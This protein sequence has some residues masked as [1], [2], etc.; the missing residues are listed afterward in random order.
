MLNAQRS[1]GS[2]TSLAHASEA[3]RQRGD[4]VEGARLAR[5]AIALAHSLAQVSEQANMLRLLANQLLRTGDMEDAARAAGEAAALEAKLDNPAG[6]ARALTLQSMAYLELGL[7]EEA[8]ETL[9]VSLEIA[10]RLRDPELLF[11]A[12][13]RVGNA[14]SNLGKHTEARNFLRLALPFST[15]LGAES[16]FCILNNLASNAADIA[17]QATEGHDSARL[18]DALTSGLRHALDALEL[19]RAANHP[20]REAICLGNYGMLLSF[21]G[22]QAGATTAIARSRD[23]AIRKGYVSL[24]LDADYGLARIAT[25]MGDIAVAIARFEALLPGLIESD[26]KPVVVEVHR[27]LSD[28]YQDS[29]QPGQALAHYKAYHGLESRMRSSIVETR[30]RMV[31]SMTE[32][33]AALLEAERAKLE[34]RLHQMQLAELET[35]RRELLLRTHDL[36][37]KAHED[38]LTGLKNRRYAHGALAERLAACPPGQTVC[39]A[40]ADA[41][42]FKSVNDRFGHSTGDDVLRR[43]ASLL[44]AGLGPDDFVARLGGEE[45]LLVMTGRTEAMAAA[46]EARRQ[47]VEDGPWSDIAEDLAVSISIGFAAVGAG[48][49]VSDALARADTALYQSKSSGRN[50]MTINL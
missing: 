10:Q 23:I 45:F 5:D 50:R 49:P 26:E 46:C 33:S 43:L 12:Y 4:Y 8:L 14:H 37:R 42:H 28:L 20:Y 21:T 30:M 44:S 36:D 41:D 3:A 48:E 18:A 17:A 35:E 24:L 16:K 29:D 34:T 40:M 47:S 6:R 27:L 25:R 15:G 32:L 7:T 38:D 22:D 1:Q 39:V 13:N 9:A 2:L 19:A 31:T 11:W